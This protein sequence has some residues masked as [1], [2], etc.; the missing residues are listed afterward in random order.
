MYISSAIGQYNIIFDRFLGKPIELPYANFDSIKIQPNDIATST[1]INHSLEKLYTNFLYLYKCSRVAS[2]V[3]PISSCGIAGVS[4]NNPAPLKPTR[5]RWSTVKDN[6]STSQ[7]VALSTANLW[8]Q[9]NITNFAVAKN[10]TNDQFSI[11]TSS[12]KDI[13]VYNADTRFFTNSI[14]MNQ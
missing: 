4:A 12:G 11:F 10:Y 9:D 1:V 7:L 14:E 2:N 3:I 13:V 5:F 6:L 8:G